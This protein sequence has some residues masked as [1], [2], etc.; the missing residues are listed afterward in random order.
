MPQREHS[1]Q[2]V[3]RD[4]LYSEVLRLL[5]SSKGVIITG[6]AGTGKTSAILSIVQSSCFT[7]TRSQASQSLQTLASQVLGYHFCQAEN[8]DTCSVGHWVHNLAYQ[9]SQVP[10]LSSYHALLSTQTDISASLA[11]ARC[12]ADP[13]TA[14]LTGILQPLQTLRD[15]GQIT[16]SHGVLLID[17]LCED[18]LH[19][20]DYGDTI[21]SFINQYLDSF[22]D[23]LH[24]VCSVRSDKKEITCK[25]PFQNIR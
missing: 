17:A 2:L 3:W 20:P 23:W 21:A 11:L 25:L 8:S 13:G 18:D 7:Q 10:G 4:W 19:R 24:V 5:D 1:A 15:L 6:A 9:L 12:I 14:L 22:P 16:L